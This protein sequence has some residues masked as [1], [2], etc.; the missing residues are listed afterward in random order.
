MTPSRLLLAVCLVACRSAAAPAPPSAPEQACA[1]AL[2]LLARQH[3]PNASTIYLAEIAVSTDTIRLDPPTRLT[4]KQGYVNQ[5]AFTA[6]GGGVY[7]TWRPDGS[8]ADIWFHD[9][10]THEEHPVTCSSEEEY[11]ASPT[12]DGKGLTVVRVNPDLGRT[13]TVLGLDGKPRQTLFPRLVTVGAYRWADDHTIA[14]LL[15]EP[16]APSR[17]V[18]GDV[19]SENIVSVAEQVGASLAVIPGTHAISYIDNSDEHQANLMRLDVASHATAKLLALPDGV[20]S[21]AWLADGSVLAGSGT[22]ILRASPAEP[23]WRE[24]ADLSSQ[25]HGTIARLIISDDQRR[26]AIVVRPGA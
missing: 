21:V 24:V 17:I 23:S 10:R 14:M 18:L 2:P 4:T 7:F 11:L 8:Q 22:Q 9:L 20:D 25:L 16:D 15:F 6:G 26:L 19:R 3:T 13:M 12:P 5:P 1:S